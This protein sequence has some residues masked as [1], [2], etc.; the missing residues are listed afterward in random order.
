MMPNDPAYGIEPEG[1]EGKLVTIG[2]DGTKTTEM[3]PGKKGCY[4]HIFEAVHHTIRDN[5]LFPV[6]EE[7]VAWQIELLEN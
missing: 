4:E 7:Q 5:A 6:T 2:I 1:N 3:I